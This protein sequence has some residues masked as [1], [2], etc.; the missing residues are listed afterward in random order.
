MTCGGSYEKGAKGKECTVGT[1][2]RVYAGLCEEAGCG[3]GAL[4]EGA[5]SGTPRMSERVRLGESSTA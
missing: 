5:G 1:S 4:W 3:G 2:L